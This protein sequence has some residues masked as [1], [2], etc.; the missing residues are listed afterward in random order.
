MNRKP[1]TLIELLIVIAIIAILAALL[2]PALNNARSQAKSIACANNMKQ[3]ALGVQM[4]VTESNDYLFQTSVTGVDDGWGPFWHFK[5]YEQFGGSAVWGLLPSNYNTIYWCYEDMTVKSPTF[6]APTAF[7]FGYVSYGFNTFNLRGF[8]VAK[9][10]NPSDRICFAESGV[11]GGEIG[12]LACAS[13][14]STDWSAWPATPRHCGSCNIM[15]NDGHVSAV[16]SPN[17]LSNGLYDAS[18]LGSRGW[19]E[20]ENGGSAGNKWIPY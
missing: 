4:Y 8:K 13:F 5:V 16:H 6:D 9:I 1:F 20:P 11:G 12:Y 15:W 10:N 7:A 19:W 2:L 18:V 14:F 17:K 3:I